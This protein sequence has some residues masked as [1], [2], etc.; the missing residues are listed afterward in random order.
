MDSLLSRRAFL[1]AVPVGVLAAS[2][3]RTPAGIAGSN[4]VRLQ[5]NF[6]LNGPVNPNYIYVVAI[7]VFDPPYGT[8]TSVSDPTQGPAPVVDVGSVNGVVGG[9][10]SHYVIYTEQTPNLYQVYRF[11]TQQEAPNPN[12]PNTPINLTWPGRYVGDV[13]IGSGVD[14]RPTFPGGTYGSTLGFAIDTS[15]LDQFSPDPT[16]LGNGIVTIQFNILTMNLTALT[17]QN[18]SNRVMDAI[19]NQSNIGNQ[20]FVNPVQINV[21]TGQTVTDTSAGVTETA[22]DT[23]PAGSNLPSVDMTG[24]S[25]LVST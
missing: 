16:A 25:L 13:I 9:L 23:F 1:A 14:P 5:F 21:T 8:G 10:P 19:G 3:A 4:A 6:T 20:T 2:C 12:D 7:R 15:Y 11:P 22:N 18:V 24:W 17:S